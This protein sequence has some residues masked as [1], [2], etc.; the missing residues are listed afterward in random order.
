MLP[1]NVLTL[2]GLWLRAT[3][4]TSNTSGQVLPSF[5]A[6]NTVR[7]HSSA[8]ENW[9]Q[10]RSTKRRV[11]F[12]ISMKVLLLSEWKELPHRVSTRAPKRASRGEEKVRDSMVSVRM[13][14][15]SIFVF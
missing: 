6:L 7:A 13:M 10:T 9:G 3:S 4:I 14:S 15:A 8:V 5:F 12:S 2:E 1:I 11:R